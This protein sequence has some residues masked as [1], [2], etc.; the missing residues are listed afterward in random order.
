MIYICISFLLIL[1]LLEFCLNGKRLSPTIVMHSLWGGVLVLCAFYESSIT[2]ISFVA[3]F[4]ILVGNLM[5]FLGGLFSKLPFNCLTA[6][7]EVRNINLLLVAPFYIIMILIIF[8]MYNEGKSISENWYMGIR[9]IINYGEPDEYFKVFGYLYYFIYPVLYISAVVK[10]KNPNKENA[11][12]FYFHLFLSL[13]YAFFSTAKIKLLLMVLP[14]FF[15]RSYYKPSSTKLILAIV[16][17][18]LAGMYC[19]LYLLNKIRGNDSFTDMLLSNIGSYTFANLFAFDSLDFKSFPSMDCNDTNGCQ[20]LPFYEDSYFRTNVYTVM[21]KFIDVGLL[22]YAF[23]MLFIGTLHNFFHQLARKTKSIYFVIF[24]SILYFPLFFQIMD[25]QYISSK[26]LLW[27][28]FF[29]AIWILC[30]R[31]K[32]VMFVTSRKHVDL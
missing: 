7:Y 26:Y 22:G 19:S 28:F 14:V 17:L 18:I 9:L 13:I 32:I 21:Y 1:T 16:G 6:N 24:S 11:R 4:W 3:L 25:D 29:T 27:L 10:F 23:F 20:L 8:H 12:V 31:I 2:Y 5:F 30:T 15:I